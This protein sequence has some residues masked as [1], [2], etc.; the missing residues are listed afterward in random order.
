ML[1]QKNRIREGADFEVICRYGKVFSGKGLV[2]RVR[3][4]KSILVRL[5]VSIGLR[6][7]PKAVV[8]N[9]IKR[10]IRAFFGQNLSKIKSGFDILVIIGK[11]WE[12]K[13]NPS[14]EI[15]QIL[16]KNGLFKK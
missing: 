15:R 12:E 10:Q 13:M 2:L 4:N 9:R 11:G 6:F 8:R 14:E 1:P 16:L 7:S 5:G 3:E